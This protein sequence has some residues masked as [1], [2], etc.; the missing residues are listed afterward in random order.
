[1]II[2]EEIEGQLL[3]A[4]I[5]NRMRN[6]MKIAAVKAPRYGEERRSILEDVATITGAT[7]VSK[8][9]ALRL[10]AVKLEHLGSVKKVEITKYHTTLA[11]GE[12][13]YAALDERIEML[14]GQVEET[15]SLPEAQRIQ[16]RITRLSS[17]IAVIRIGGATEIEVTEKK[18]RVEDAL[19]AVKSAQEEGIVLG[20]G[21]ALLKAA[22]NIEVEP[23]NPDQLR[24]AQALLESC[25]APITQILKNAEI[26]SDIVVNSLSY[27]DHPKNVGFNVRTEKFEDLI[28]SGVI[29]PAK[30]VK[31]ALQ[32]A[33]SAAGTLLTTNCAVLRKD[34]E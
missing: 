29:D 14:K 12:T 15:E 3:A 2:A 4:L 30:T 27:D 16:E 24:G 10:K 20:G 1:V 33:A 5:I 18:H 32:N 7:F 8:D 6:N 19:E 13:D 34:G 9:S 25:F 22:N 17:A 28:E 11:D 31:C 21:A 26:S 23:D